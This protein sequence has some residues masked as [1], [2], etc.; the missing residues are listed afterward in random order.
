MKIQEKVKDLVEVRHYKGLR[1]FHADPS[2]TLESYCFTDETATLMARWI[3]S[4]STIG[5]G[6]GKSLALAGYRG[7]GK[8]HFLAT[9]GSLLALPEL[10]SK[11]QNPH[12]SAATQGL[13]RRHYPLLNV[14][15][16]T[17]AT[18]I[19]ELKSAISASIGPEAV[20][21]AGSITTLLERAAA[22]SGDVPLV[23]IVDTA[24]DRVSRV[25][26][27]DGDELAEMSA[28]A[29][30]NN[31]ILA[32][33]LDDDIAGADGSNSAIVRAFNIDFLDQQH[34]FKVVNS[35]I[36]PKF[37]QKISLI[38][39]IYSFFSRVVP[40]FRWSSQ[41]FVSLY[42]LH[43]GIL[44]VA[45]YVR[46]FV[47][48]F[49]L[50]GFAAEAG[51]RILGRPATSLIAFDE[52][53][54]NA[55][56]GLRKVKDLED[57]FAAYD[58]LN[59]EVVSKVP[60][61]QRLQAKLILKALLLH[62]LNGRGATVEEICAS[63]MIYDESDPSKA[64]EGASGIIKMFADA[65]PDDISWYSEEGIGV[66]YSF[67]AN[68]KENANIVLDE[69]IGRTDPGVVTEILRKLLQERYPDLTLTPAPDNPNLLSS[70]SSAIW[71]G[72]Q[73]RGRF[74]AALDDAAVEV[75]GTQEESLDWRIAL[76]IRGVLRPSTEAALAPDCVLWRPDILRKDEID[77]LLRF[78]VL[79]TQTEL[80][81]TFGDQH[82]ALL[83]SQR[84]AA[85]NIAERVFLANGNL[86]INGF[87]FN[88]TEEA[89]ASQS[90]SGLISAMLDPMFETQYPD[91]PAFGRALGIK[92][93]S[94]TIADFF[95]P[96]KTGL[97]ETQELARAFLAPLG[98]ATEQDGNLTP[99]VGEYLDQ[100]PY[101]TTIN[102]LLDATGDGTA[103]IIGVYQSLKQPPYGFVREAQ[104][105][106]LASLVADRRI[107]FVTAKGDRINAR[108]LDLKI[109]W[110]DIVGIARPIIAD[111]PAVSNIKWAQLLTGFDD[112]LSDK[113]SA[114]TER[115]LE[116]LG[117]W[118][119]E[120]N[121]ANLLNRFDKVPDALVN[122]KIWL[123]ASFVKKT[124]GRVVET[125]THLLAGTTRL[126]Q[127]L[128]DIADAFSHS[129]TEFEKSVAG[130]ERIETFLS[131]VAIRQRIVAYTT[132]A[133]FAP[134]AKA[135]DTKRALL[136]CI[137]ESIRNPGSARNREAGY[138]WDGY[139][140]QY[141]DA[142][143]NEHSRIMRSHELQERFESIRRTDI[144]WEFESLSE[145]P[146]L[147]TPFWQKA[148]ELSGRLAE[149]DCSFESSRGLEHRA[150]CI[151]EFD[152]SALNDWEKMSDE[153]WDA[154]TSGHN[155][156]REKIARDCERLAD[157]SNGAMST[158]KSKQD[159]EAGEAL[160]A[161][162]RVGGL[163]RLGKSE[164]D[165]LRILYRDLTARRPSNDAGPD[166]SDRYSVS[167]SGGDP[168]HSELATV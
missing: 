99:V 18:L 157:V 114:G 11:I 85:V 64:L 149:L 65:L 89:M 47:Q 19:E 30:D 29:A 78:Y 118:L 97:E 17:H 42:P 20:I 146:Q 108:S 46:L 120:W 98:L 36:F 109:V 160:F 110:G 152:V 45:P 2:A 139:R 159:A 74:F 130:L 154:V 79:Q 119:E 135:N 106:I 94:A 61:I 122:T 87:D 90:I 66:L 71:R 141:Q 10:R 38:E 158:I 100:L 144:W 40:N 142:F 91:H 67:R 75:I 70:E 59:A 134:D 166:S 57:A 124:L 126:D 83:H 88:F 103:E 132:P 168:Q 27:N 63:M 140:S 147:R 51:E 113:G 111:H 92:D 101:I 116:A 77:T 3:D 53:F 32:V 5:P 35:F 112:E 25:S 131:S 73:R 127:A 84:V 16:G 50:L 86:V 48:D 7:V 82:R 14:R 137:S 165:I 129:E 104:H 143:T 107:E 145:I 133:G 95:D 28:F 136:A 26:R 60:V 155:M 24:H 12:V 21:G 151:C 33:G 52:V 34:L 80:I 105:L 162:L 8:S 153:L 72:G 163:R 150:G 43:P 22:R 39:E 164:I 37:N 41:R 121:T 49:A 117:A 156:I 68:A 1:D 125:I 62:S 56:A 102:E 96:A 6:K 115:V 44:D 4:A 58:R 31:V 54:D 55:E 69:A 93:V 167:R 148:F 23:I 123:D 128:G 138:L 15:R 161:G 81:E 13:L 9:F 76:D